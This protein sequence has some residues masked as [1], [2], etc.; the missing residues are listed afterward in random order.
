MGRPGDGFKNSI[1]EDSF[2][3]FPRLLDTSISWIWPIN[4]DAASSA[5]S[6][7]TKIVFF[8]ATKCF[9]NEK[10]IKM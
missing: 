9:C 2:H 5:Q 6:Q 10:F 8:V 1:N 4:V 3:V 7:R